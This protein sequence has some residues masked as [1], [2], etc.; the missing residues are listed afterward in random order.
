MPERFELPK[1]E[2]KPWVILDQEENIFEIGGR[3]LPENS[4]KLFSPIK[5]WITE[6]GNSPNRLTNFVFKFDYFNSSSA[7]RIIEIFLILKKIKEGN[8]E[9]KITWYFEKDDIL[10]KEKGHEM[11]SMIEIPF[12]ILEI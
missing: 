8:N 11:L 6:Y 12:D 3:S 9:V 1:S 4:E 10:L 7:R 5:K 2:D